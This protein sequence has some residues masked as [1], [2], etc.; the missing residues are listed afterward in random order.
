MLYAVGNA[1]WW[2]AMEA[3]YI[4]P[5][6]LAAEFSP[7]AAADLA[8]R[9][10]EPDVAPATPAEEVDERTLDV[11]LS[12]PRR[13][14]ASKLRPAQEH[15]LHLTLENGAIR[16][17]HTQNARTGLSPKPSGRSRVVGVAKGG[18]WI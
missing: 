7:A 10:V 18:R 15:F 13:S 2:A 3:G 11:V 1:A 5:K 8:Q 9:G 4:K 12:L 6:D 16:F 14:S 17:Y